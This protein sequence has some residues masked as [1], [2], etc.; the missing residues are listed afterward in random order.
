MA[1]HIPWG[2]CPADRPVDVR[3]RGGVNELLDV[4]SLQLEFKS[5]EAQILGLVFDANDDFA[6]RWTRVGSICLTEFPSFPEV[7]P[8]DGGVIVS[9]QDGRRL[10]V[11]IMPDNRSRGMTETFLQFLVPGSA[12]ALLKYAKEVVREARARGAPFRQ[13]HLDKAVIHAWLAWQDPPGLAFGSA[14]VQN[15]LDSS[16]PYA[17]P[18]VNWFRKL[19]HL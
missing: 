10:G 13:H 17:L 9:N 12:D 5:S 19:Y 18:F 15:C 14:I 4:A 7:V 8:G 6:G 11:W 2:N 3:A 1:K 16:S